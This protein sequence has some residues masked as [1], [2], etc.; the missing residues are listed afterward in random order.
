MNILII[1]DDVYIRQLLCEIL[2]SQNHTIFESENGID[3]LDYFKK[4]KI[5]ICFLDVWMPEIG[6][7]DVLT[8]IKED[9]VDVEV[10]MISGDAKVNQAVKATKLGAYDFLEKPLVID[11]VISIV[12]NIE[13]FKKIKNSEIKKA[14]IDEEMV[15][16]SDEMSKIKSLIDSAAKSEARILILGENGTG[17]ELVAR[18]IHNQSLRKN[19]PFVSI[20]CAAIPENLIESEM[21][22]HVKGAFTGAVNDREGKFVQANRGT[23]F[24]DEVADMS[25]PTQAKLL[26][27]LQEMK[28]TPIGSTELLDIDVR[29]IAATNKN[30]KKEIEEGNFREDLFYRLNVIPFHLPPLRERKR[31]IPLLVNYFIKK[32]SSENGGNEKMI[33]VPG[34][35]YLIEYPWPG[36]IRQLRNIIE[37]LIVMVADDIIDVDDV[38]KYID[39]EKS[40]KNINDIFASKYDEYKLNV[41]REEFERDFIQR[42]L[43][44]NNFNVSKTAKVLGVY[45]SNLYLKINKLGIDVDD[46]KK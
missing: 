27:V 29:V 16:I 10:V 23:L 28:L 1:D 9:F 35:D 19:K 21:F 41:A 45:P 6:G 25:L 15:G 38:K 44:E 8:R 42:K 4:Q 20:N 7:I 39:T 24:L 31:D 26:R 12:N 14:V 46:D 11:D 36:N 30:I 2:V 34:L 5:D 43:V 22:G 37:R 18:A 33:T 17:K 32:L 3:G 13:Q 40:F